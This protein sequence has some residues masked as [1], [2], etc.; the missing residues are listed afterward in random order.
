MKRLTYF[1][2]ALV[3]ST[4]CYAQGDPDMVA[5][6]IEEGKTRNQ[7]R[8]HLETLTEQI[9]SRLT[10]S[11]HLEAGQA[12]AMDLFKSWG[13][14]NVHLEKWGEWAVGFDRTGAGHVA[15]MTA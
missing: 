3:A 10:S 1:G 4:A 6:I 15:R 11:S 8:L 13:C 9:G 12:W 5:K 14:Q 2:L 7:T